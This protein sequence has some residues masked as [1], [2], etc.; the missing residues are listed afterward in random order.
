MALDESA[1]D[2]PSAAEELVDLSVGV[3]EALPAFDGLGLAS[4]L[5]KVL[6]HPGNVARAAGGLG[7]DLARIGM[8]RVP[9][10]YEPKDWRF[11]NR[12]WTDNPVFRRLGQSYLAWERQM[13]RLV[14]EA[15]LDWRT[16]ARA[17]FAMTLLTTALAPTNFLPTNPD[18]LVRAFETGGASVARGGR[19]LARD[20]LHNR[21]MPR[22]VDR[23][24]F[25]VGR[26]LA[27][28]PG[29]VVYRDDVLELIQY[30]PVTPT[31]LSRPTVVV[32]PQINRYYVMDLA[33]GRSFVEYA[34]S[35]G[36]QTF[37]VSWRNPPRWEGGW[38]L[39]TYV[40]A[41]DRAVGAAADITGVPDVNVVAVCAGGITTAAY[42]GHLAAT[43]EH[44]IHAAT[45][46]VTLLDFEQP[47]MLGMLADPKVVEQAA[48]SS[49]REGFMEGDALGALFAALRPN[50][51]VWNYWVSNNLLG[52][53]PPQ[54][55][56]LAWNADTLRMPAGLHHDYLG[57]F[58]HNDLVE[59][60]MVA[61]GTPVELEKV[62]ADTLVVAGATDHLTPW[63]ACYRTTQLLG[64][65]SDFV[66]CSSG[67]IQSLVNPAGG[68]RMSYSVGGPPGPDPDE[69]AAS[70][71][72]HTGSW[73]EH[74]A[75]WVA[76]RSG[77]PRP[78]PELRGDDDHPVLAPAP[79]T[80]V[81]GR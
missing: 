28:T 18:A 70:A 36:V 81:F 67:H 3:R 43:G 55:D 72:S 19:N 56:I 39:D 29:A 52:D 10:A 78:A 21:G 50:D 25:E 44:R 11:R 31:V 24:P 48:T 71:T 53:D 8:G 69:W 27:A 51:L 80:Y 17:R 57:V 26:N 4:A 5:A 58:L 38:N 14:D 47:T 64:G 33:P 16:E 9:V 45:F 54:F 75:T 68:T 65:T 77:P 61:L 42:L 13:H 79:G 73:W 40:A 7:V 32:P 15:D 63:R 22:S 30:D 12:A 62:T 74:W 23:S 60:R 41:L 37:A 6:A 1:D 20:V 34:V 35:Q 66:L 2:L 59:G 46:A 76:P 49:E